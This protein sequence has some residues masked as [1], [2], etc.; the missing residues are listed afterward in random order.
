MPLQVG[1]WKAATRHF[2]FAEKESGR[3]KSGARA[4]STTKLTSLAKSSVFASL[5]LQTFL[6][7]GYVRR[8]VRLFV[9]A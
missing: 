2:L 9:L 3:K 1:P 5:R 7:L 8:K 6:T 4:S